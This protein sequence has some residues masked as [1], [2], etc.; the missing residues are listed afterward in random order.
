[1]ER[2]HSCKKF[3]F[4]VEKAGETEEPGHAAW[5]EEDR[6]KPVNL[7]GVAKGRKKGPH[8]KKKSNGGV[9]GARTR[10][11]RKNEGEI[12]SS[13]SIM[14]HPPMGSGM[15]KN[16]PGDSG[17]D[18]KGTQEDSQKKKYSPSQKQSSHEDGTRGNQGPANGFHQLGKGQ[19][20]K[21]DGTA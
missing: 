6:K 8:R 5:N 15:E 19:K 20:G 4:D 2:K 11:E 10:G 14:H 7:S 3:L 12:S 9:G 16:D 18:R 13:S 1:M 17:Q 21:P